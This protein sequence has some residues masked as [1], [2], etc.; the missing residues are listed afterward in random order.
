MNNQNIGS[1]DQ[2]DT[3]LCSQCESVMIPKNNVYHRTCKACWRANYDKIKSDSNDCVACRRCGMAN[4]PKAHARF[5]PV[6]VQ[7]YKAQQRELRHDHKL[8]YFKM[9]QYETYCKEQAIKNGQPWP[10]PKS[11]R[12]TYGKCSNV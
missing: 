9:E 5:K 8:G 2:D 7:C 3:R 12:P 6:C 4:V 11:K 10:P 1:I